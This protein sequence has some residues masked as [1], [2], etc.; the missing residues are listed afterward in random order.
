MKALYVLR[1]AIVSIEALLISAAVFI[2]QYF[3]GT[4]QGVAVALKI[5]EEVLK[6]GMFLP[7]GLVAWVLLE[8]RNLL[9]EDS[10]TLKLLKGW[11]DYWKLKV[12]VW[13]A[14]TYSIVF[15]V[16]SL[17]PWVTADGISSAKGLLWFTTSIIGQ[18]AVALSVYKARMDQKE[19]IA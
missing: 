10:Q 14:I 9:Q 17:A 18:L 12:H 13:V 3:S 2:G 19:V 5:N 4:I 1:V 11:N 15:A 16:I 8:C 7:V 6:Y